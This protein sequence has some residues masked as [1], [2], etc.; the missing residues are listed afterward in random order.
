[1]DE[2][3]REK[4]QFI[5][6]VVNRE[7]GSDQRSERVTLECGHSFR[8]PLMGGTPASAF[9]CMLC[10]QELTGSTTRYF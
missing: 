5:H 6:P 1:M 3:Y 4:N 2:L 10:V 9:R 8:V 7:P